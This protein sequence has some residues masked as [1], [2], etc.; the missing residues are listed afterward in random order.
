M[1]APLVSVL[2][3]A[4]N[5]EKYIAEAIESV[6]A[7]TFQDSELIVVDDASKDSTVEI[8][9]RYTADPRVQVHVNETNLGDY[10]NRNRAAELARGKYLKYVDSDDI[11]YPHGLEVMVRSMERFPG[12]GLGLSRPAIPAE[13]YPVQ[14]TPEQAYWE[15]F[16][17][18]GLLVNA[19]LSAIIRANAFR[20]VGGFSGRRQIGDLELWLRVAARYP[21]VKIVRDLVWWRAHGDQEYAY[22]SEADKS[23]MSLAVCVAAL[24]APDCPLSPEDRDHALR[25]LKHQYARGILHLAVKQRQVRT[26]YT[27]VRD[28]HLSL[29]DLAQGVARTE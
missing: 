7:S 13:P 6:L 10:P 4:Y 20:A 15:H 5:R 11:I 25:R 8:A 22:D 18:P 16:L 26:A 9:R 24:Q 14:L 2:M 21:I 1:N 29:I 3:T 27:L 28:A 19:P 12:T 23:K 17:G